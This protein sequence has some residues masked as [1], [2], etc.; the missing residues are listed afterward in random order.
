[1]RDIIMCIL[2]QSSCFGNGK[3]L[4]TNSFLKKDL[5]RL[6]LLIRSVFKSEAANVLSSYGKDNILD[7]LTGTVGRNSI[8]AKKK[9]KIILDAVLIELLL[10]SL[11]KVMAWFS[12]SR[13]DSLSSAF[14]ILDFTV[15]L[16]NSLACAVGPIDCENSK[17]IYIH[18]VDSVLYYHSMEMDIYQNIL[19]N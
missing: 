12:S 19:L 17:N 3:L 10:S 1:M 15:F 8:L 6:M 11:C 7:P 5:S 16:T 9:K 4:A 14:F 2:L 13:S 18:K